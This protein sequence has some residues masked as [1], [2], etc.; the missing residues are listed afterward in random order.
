[1]RFIQSIAAAIA[2]VGSDITLKKESEMWAWK[3]KKREE[4]KE[5]REREKERE[6]ERGNFNSEHSDD[7][8]EKAH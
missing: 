7:P 3:K 6:K 2:H 4:V 1:M 5:E 8:H